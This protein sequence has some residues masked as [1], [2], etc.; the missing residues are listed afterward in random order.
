MPARP[1]AESVQTTRWSPPS[2]DASGLPARPPAEIWIGW[3]SSS[4][5]AG[6]IRSPRMVLELSHTTRKLV[7]SKAI[8]GRR[9]DRAERRTPYGSTTAPDCSTRASHSWR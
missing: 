8:D 3:S 1:A 9:A 6:L 2:N 5:P 7:P 4:A